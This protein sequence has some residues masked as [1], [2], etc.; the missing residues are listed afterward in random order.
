MKKPYRMKKVT[1]EFEVDEAAYS[2]AIRK[3]GKGT[4]VAIAQ[5][6]TI[7][8]QKLFMSLLHQ[9]NHGIDPES[10]LEDYALQT[11][12]LGKLHAKKTEQLVYYFNIPD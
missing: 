8:S 11:R 4:L 3:A 7:S 2:Q 5:E 12:V 6:L 1:I 9:I 10:P